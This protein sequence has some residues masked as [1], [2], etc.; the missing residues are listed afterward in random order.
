M[1]L[2]AAALVTYSYWVQPCAAAPESGCRPGD[3]EL[4]AWAFAAW[5]RAAE[6]LL[7]LEA[8]PDEAK[9]QLRL[10]WV[11]PRQHVY[12]EA[13]SILIEGKRVAEMHILPG[14]AG[15]RGRKDRLFRDAVIYLTCLHESGHA[16]GLPH[17]ARFEDIMY[18][19]SFGGD[20]GE[21]FARYRRNLKK[22]EDV[23]RYSG[24]S[25]SDAA[26]LRKLLQ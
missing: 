6:G 18:S 8:E 5:E 19:F 13:R 26:G 20:L 21:Y 15:P 24:M 10:Y 7:R 3:V 17:T 12:G 22:R 1:T 25:G 11:S 16:L 14:V 4:A 2:F 9:A 23:R